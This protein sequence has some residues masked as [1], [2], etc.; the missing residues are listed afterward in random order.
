MEI[1]VIGYGDYDRATCVS[2][3]EDFPNIEEFDS[4]IIDLTAFPKSL[5]LPI[6]ITLEEL[7]NAV[8]TLITTGREIFCVMNEPMSIFGMGNVNYLWFPNANNL[9]VISRKSGKSKTVRDERFKGYFEYVGEWRHEIEYSSGFYTFSPICV[10]KSGNAIACTVKPDVHGM[11]GSIHLLPRTTEV[12]VTDSIELLIDL[13]L[14]KEITE[15]P[16]RKQI[17]IQGLKEIEAEIEGRIE[18]IDRIQREIEDWKSKWRERERYRDLFSKDDDRIPEAVQRVLADLGLETKETPKG[19]VVDLLGEKTA[20]EV[21]S[22]KGKVNAK[23]KKVIQLSR[24]IEEER[25]DEKVILVANTYKELP[26]AER[27]G[28]VDISVPMERFLK[29]VQACFITTL[30]LYGL[31]NRVLKKEMSAE[32]A[33]KLIISTVGVLAS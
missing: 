1:L 13:A 30:A 10:N 2:W 23:S 25:K 7:K 17:E 18:G 9:S 22:I 31:W 28:K 21:T 32:D 6:M 24:F 3:H 20:V 26:L 11:K 16:W 12:S 29:S 27:K 19:Y 14:G 15:Y 33:R 4:V 5:E 8:H